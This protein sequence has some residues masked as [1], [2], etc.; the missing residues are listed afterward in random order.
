MIIAGSPYDLSA[1]D[2]VIIVVSAV[3]GTILCLCFARCYR[4]WQKR[5]IEG[6]NNLGLIES[7]WLFTINVIISARREEATLNYQ[8]RNRQSL[9]FN[10]DSENRQ[11]TPAPR[12]INFSRVSVIEMVN[13]SP[14]DYTKAIESEDKPPA[15]TT[16]KIGWREYKNTESYN[17]A[18]MY[19]QYLKN[20]S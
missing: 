4:N 2:I 6:S 9:R 5:M 15:Y 17:K 7:L 13:D 16:I 11:E 10:A 1:W 20:G 3:G 14:P 12:P 19:C 18:N 8:P